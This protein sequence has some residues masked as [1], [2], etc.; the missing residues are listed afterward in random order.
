L[1]Y[2]VAGFGQLGRIDDA[3][4]GLGELKAFDGNL[5]AVEAGYMRTYQVRDSID[6]ILDGLR[7]AGF[8]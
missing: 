6:H 7:K 1:R 5:T 8:E 2:A 4:V 3:R